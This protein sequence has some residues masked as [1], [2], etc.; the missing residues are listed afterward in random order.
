MSHLF[1]EIKF[2][3]Y[4]LPLNSKKFN[5]II[6]GVSFHCPQHHSEV[7]SAFPWSSYLKRTL[8]SSAPTAHCEYAYGPS[9]GGPHVDRRLCASMPIWDMQFCPGWELWHL[10]A[11]LTRWTMKLSLLGSWQHCEE[12]GC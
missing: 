6:V 3:L 10:E 1:L 9:P 8:S 4:Q 11:N 5:F 12:P 2:N 7:P